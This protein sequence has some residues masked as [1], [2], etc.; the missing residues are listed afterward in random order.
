MNIQ[1]IIEGIKACLNDNCSNCPYK[2][3]D[4]K[5]LLRNVY[6][7]LTAINSGELTEEQ[8]DKAREY[9]KEQKRILRL[10]NKTAKDRAQKIKDEMTVLEKIEML[11]THYDKLPDELKPG[12]V[13]YPQVFNFMRMERS[14]IGNQKETFGARLIAFRDKYNLSV[15]DFC[16]MCNQYAVQFDGFSS[17]KKPLKTRVNPEDIRSYENYNVSPK[18]D[19]LVCIKQAMAF[20]MAYF[21]GYG[22]GI[23]PT[24]IASDYTVKPFGPSSTNIQLEARFRKRRTP[25][26]KKTS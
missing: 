26:D 3:E 8:L 6:S 11:N 17:R 10:Q 19:K 4:G 22:K 14:N 15:E 23:P 18:I 25:P 20:D 13:K 7:A 5:E 16:K 24:A 12:M 1:E 21:T 2:C 9:F